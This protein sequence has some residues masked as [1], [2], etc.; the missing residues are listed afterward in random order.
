MRVSGCLDGRPAIAKRWW[1]EAS[2]RGSNGGAHSWPLAD[3]GGTKAVI[4]DF[5]RKAIDLPLDYAKREVF[6]SSSSASGIVGGGRARPI[7]TQA[8]LPERILGLG[9]STQKGDVCRICRSRIG[10]HG[11]GFSGGLAGRLS[12]PR[13]PAGE[14]VIARDEDRDPVERTSAC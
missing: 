3:D 14:T 12:A 13:A 6:P 5:H 1:P 4:Y 2:G 10:W 8:H 11:P 9:S 7:R